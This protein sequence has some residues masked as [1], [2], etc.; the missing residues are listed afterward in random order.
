[1]S[2]TN[3]KKTEGGGVLSFFSFDFF[4]R[5]FG[6]FL[7][8]ARLNIFFGRFLHTLQFS[9]YFL[10]KSP[11]KIRLVCTSL[12]YIFSFSAPWR[13][14]WR[15]G[16]GGAGAVAVAAAKK[17]EGRRTKNAH[18]VLLC[19]PTLCPTGTPINRSIR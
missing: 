17:K 12:L 3:P 16:G 14:R 1:M 7:S 10:K 11:K 9:T 18:S 15:P 19:S 8:I 5:V 6:R 13:W 4:N 2:K